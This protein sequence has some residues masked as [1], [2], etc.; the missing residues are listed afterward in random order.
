VGVPRHASLL[1]KGDSSQ[2]QVYPK[3]T[4]SIHKPH[5][6]VLKV[7]PD[8]V[9]LMS[10]V[11]ESR[12]DS[13]STLYAERENLWLV[14]ASQPLDFQGRCYLYFWVATSRHKRDISIMGQ[15]GHVYFGMTKSHAILVS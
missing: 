12:N 11:A 14:A 3:S 10:R 9:C 2:K 5:A 15:S 4:K 8:V 1:E 13:I 7:V 6:T